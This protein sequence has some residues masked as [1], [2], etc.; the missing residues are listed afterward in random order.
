MGCLSLVSLSVSCCLRGVATWSMR[1]TSN[2]AITW[3]ASFDWS[4]YIKRFQNPAACMRF[5][6][7]QTESSRGAHGLESLE[8][9]QRF[10]D[11][12]P[13]IRKLSGEGKKAK[14]DSQSGSESGAKTHVCITGYTCFPAGVSSRVNSLVL[15][16]QVVLCRSGCLSLGSAQRFGGSY[17]L[18]LS[19]SL[20]SLLYRGGRSS[21]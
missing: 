3:C 18:S 19:L 10:I 4:V 20:L 8:D 2:P 16:W 12:Y 5:T 15:A 14:V 7:C 21:A 9:M 13:E 17:V 1:G 11:S 6:F